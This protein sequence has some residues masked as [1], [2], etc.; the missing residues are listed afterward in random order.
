MDA[1]RGVDLGGCNT[2]DSRGGVFSNG[3]SFAVPPGTMSPMG[4]L[5]TN[6]VVVLPR[7]AEFFLGEHISPA[8]AFKIVDVDSFVTPLACR[9]THA[10]RLEYVALYNPALPDKFIYCKAEFGAVETPCM[11]LSPSVRVVRVYVCLGVC[12]WLGVRA[13]G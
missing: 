12:K 10:G 5:V 2:I 8:C 13:E 3:A 4:M 11:K 7:G 1:L 9:R 6:S